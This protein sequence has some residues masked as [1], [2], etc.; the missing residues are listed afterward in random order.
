MRR[1]SEADRERQGQ[2]VGGEKDE[3]SMFCHA[4]NDRY[5]SHLSPEGLL[6]IGQQIKSIFPSLLFEKFNIYNNLLLFGVSF[7]LAYL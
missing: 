7:S 2:G 3:E 6:L 4:A 1:D 5:A